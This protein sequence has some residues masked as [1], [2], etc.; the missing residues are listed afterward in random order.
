M[1]AHQTYLLSANKRHSVTMV[2][3]LKWWRLESSPAN[4]NELPQLELLWFGSI[5]R[6]SGTH[7]D[8]EEIQ[9]FNNF[10]HGDKIKGVL[11]KE[12][13]FEAPSRKRFHC[14]TC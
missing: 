3:I 6:S 5:M 13:L 2:M 7:R 1:S 11:L 12:T 10:P 9:P 4:T 8:G 14:P